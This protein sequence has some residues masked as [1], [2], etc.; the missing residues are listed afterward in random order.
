MRTK[1]L[2]VAASLFGMVA[3]HNAQAVPVDIAF[4]VDQSLSMGGE[5]NWIPNV[6]TAI[7]TAL[8]SEAVVT[9]TRYGLAGYMEGVGNEYPGSVIGSRV[10]DEY[11]ELA[12]VDL[13]STV[14]TVSTAATA[15]ASDLR[16]Y[17]ERGYHAADWSR[18]GFSWAAD[19]VKVMILLTDEAGDQGSTI[20]DAG[21]GSD[22]ANL[23][24]L[25]I[26]DGILLN[27]ITGTSY[28]NNWDQAVYDQSSSYQGLFDLTYLRDNPA[29]FTAQFVD[30]KIGEIKEQIDGEVPLPAT[31]MLFGLGVAAMGYRRRRVV[32]A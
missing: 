3:G 21:Q 22:E 30:A 16:R 28:Y 14:G 17:T 15:A 13:T 8:Q 25:L 29:E 19:A 18:T 27:V 23:G 6:I 10:D 4:V 12:Y 20:P 2:V 26:D 7:D 1:S 11:R 9:S 24:K 32:P 5:F 31:L